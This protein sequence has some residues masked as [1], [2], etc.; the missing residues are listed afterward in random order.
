MSF[1]TNLTTDEQQARWVPG[2]VSGELISAIAM[3]EPGAGSDLAAV[4]TTARREGEHYVLDGAKTF[5]SNGI[6]ADIVLVVAKTDPSAGHK[7]ISI[8][9]VERGMSGF[10]RGRNLDKIGQKSADTAELFFDNVRVPVT[11]LIG[12]ENR[13]FYHLMGNLPAERLGIGIHAVA[14]SKRALTLTRQYAS[15]R[16]AFGQAIGSFQVNRHALAEIQ[17]KIEVMQAYL[18]RCITAVNDGELTAEE[19][20]GERGHPGWVVGALAAALHDAVQDRPLIAVLSV[21]DDKDAAGM[22][23]ELVPLAAGAVFT[24]SRNPRA[25]SPATLASLWNQ[26]GGPPGEIEADPRSAVER[27]RALAGENGAV[28]ATGSIYLVADLLS[29]P[30]RRRASAL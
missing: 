15:D 6:L 3:S 20:G 9:A 11:N 27:A 28:V 12:E 23:R 22:L 5:I 17:T 14:M 25:L 10:S 30:G 29:E 13:G 2:L 8:V 26:L 1:C 4:R 7:G 18:D 19:A 16:K 21:L 24:A